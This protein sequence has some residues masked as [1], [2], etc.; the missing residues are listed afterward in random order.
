M[1]ELK[2]K[3]GIESFLNTEEIV[4]FGIYD[5]FYINKNPPSFTKLE[6]KLKESK[7]DELSEFIEDI[8]QIFIAVSDYIF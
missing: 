3:S 7:F 1:A 5:F 2:L 4:K 8:K 6:K